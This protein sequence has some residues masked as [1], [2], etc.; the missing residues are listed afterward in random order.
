MLKVDAI[1]SAKA[2]REP[3]AATAVA[4]EPNLAADSFIACL[5]RARHI[6]S[7]YDY[8]LLEG[9]LPEED[10]SAIAALPFA[11][12]AGAAFNGRRE[13]NNATRVL[14]QPREPRKISCLSPCRHGV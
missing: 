12:L 8:W 9:A 10:V 14:F 1:A 11:P 2:A 6:A 5:A 3:D 13:T 4:I 7:P